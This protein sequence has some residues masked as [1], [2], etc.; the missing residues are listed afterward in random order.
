MSVSV[1]HMSYCVREGVAAEIRAEMARQRKTGVELASLLNRTQ[2]S[3]SRRMNA[4][5]DISL[6]E[7]AAIAEWLGKPVS[8]FLAPATMQESA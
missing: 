4:D 2:Q 1:T 6:D 8:H 7:L 3:V 5:V